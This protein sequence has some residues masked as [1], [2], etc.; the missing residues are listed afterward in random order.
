M[1]STYKTARSLYRAAVPQ[2]LRGA[3]WNGP[4][5]GLVHRVKARLEKNADHDDLYD[6]AYYRRQ[7][8]F[9]AESGRKIAAW[10]NEHYSPH[11][12]LDVGCGS[13]AIMDGF[14]ELEIPVQGLEYSTVAIDMCTSRGLEVYKFDLESKAMPTEIQPVDLVLSTEVAEHLPEHCAD[15]Y[16]DLCCKFSKGIVLITAAVPGQGGTDHVNEQPN[17]YWIDKFEHR[18]WS[19]EREMTEKCRA[20]WKAADVDNDRARNVL[21]FSKA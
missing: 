1:P 10:L 21:I 13:G 2:S 20:D 17:E 9:M 6:A 5:G 8:G 4:L 14:R 7:Q 3:F 18:G 15:Q 19:Y 11:S 16:I 12:V